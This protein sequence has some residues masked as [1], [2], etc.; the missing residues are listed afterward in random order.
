MK[1]VE[2]RDRVK[3]D[4][5]LLNDELAIQKEQDVSEMVTIDEEDGNFLV[6]HSLLS[7]QDKI[8]PW[9]KLN[10]E[11]DVIAVKGFSA[12]TGELTWISA[13]FDFGSGQ[14]NV[15]DPQAVVHPHVMYF[16]PA[17]EEA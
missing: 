16:L 11:K 4:I 12:G 7:D 1:L 2:E 6:G 8:I 17:R 10:S 14:L 5:L 13:S 3:Q 9:V 15:V